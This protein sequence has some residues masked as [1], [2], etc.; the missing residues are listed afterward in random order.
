M[1]QIKMKLHSWFK[2]KVSININSFMFFLRQ[3]TKILWI[4]FFKGMLHKLT[5][6]VKACIAESEW[7]FG[8]TLFSHSPIKCQTHIQINYNCIILDRL[9]ATNY[10]TNVSWNLNPKSYCPVT[11]CD[12]LI[13]R[14]LSSAGWFLG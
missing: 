1:K 5:L 10:M 3:L 7:H 2:H 11:V 4:P 8:R 13:S 12:W 9:Y 6:K 14:Q